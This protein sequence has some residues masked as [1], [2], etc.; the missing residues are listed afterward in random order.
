[1]L[2]RSER[3]RQN[4]VSL[5]Q[6]EIMFVFA[7][8]ILVLLNQRELDNRDLRDANRRLAQEVHEV[9]LLAP[10]AGSAEG[11][12]E[13]RA[14]AADE[15]AL[16]QI[17]DVLVASGQLEEP[18]SESR[19]TEGRLMAEG[20]E[21]LA[22]QAAEAK[23]DEPVKNVLE[24]AREEELFPGAISDAE[25]AGAM[26]REARERSVRKSSEGAGVAQAGQGGIDRGNWADKVGFDPCW[27][28]ITEE[29]ELSHHFAFT[30]RYDSDTK[31]FMIE[32]GWDAGVPVVR[33]A[34]DW[35]LVMITDHPKGWVGKDEYAEFGKRVRD[36]ARTAYKP[37][38]LLSTRLNLSADGHTA[39]FVARFIFPVYW[40]LPPP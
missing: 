38:C 10:E 3:S 24:R 23:L 39:R 37:G 4:M 36:A 8:L 5:T 18:R 2:Q 17:R 11:T 25:I 15:R 6:T 22:R 34:L 20:V 19:E 33:D 12:G 27:E 32:P 13:M 16:E 35:R 9:R 26:L 7:A 30:T 1:M 28:K 29:G 14:R 40:D 21:E 31:L